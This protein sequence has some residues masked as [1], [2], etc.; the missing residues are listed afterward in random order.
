MEQTLGKRIAAHRKRLG[1]TQD[2]LAEKLGVTAQAVSKWEND[3]SCPDITTLPRLA[4]IFG[5]TVDALLGREPDPPVHQGVIEDEDD[6]QEP[7]GI[8]VHNGQ[9]DFSFDEG[10][11]GG[12][13]MAVLVLLVGCLSLAAA[14]LHWDVSFW[15]ILWPSAL[16]VFGV[17]GLIGRFSFFSLGCGIFG[18]YFLLTNLKVLDLNLGGELVW[19][20]ILVLFGLSLLVDTL[21]KKRRRRHVHVSRHGKNHSATCTTTSDGFSCVTSF[22]EDTHHVILPKLVNGLGEV[23]FGELTIDLSGVEA[24]DARCE[25]DAK[26]SF[27]ELIFRVPRKFRVESTSRTAF[28]SVSYHG[29]PD[30]A[31]A[32]VIFLDASVNFGE[33]SIY[34]I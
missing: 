5:T 13:G 16:L 29:E 3:Q 7:E 17:F 8:H 2:Q 20:V 33:I 32:G 18:G 31:P 25:V 14:L 1:M 19:P 27:G 11:K 30:S 21:R 10:T 4:E 26:C 12:I 34:Y 9:F 23:S 22:G 28:A 6:D 24:V 15:S